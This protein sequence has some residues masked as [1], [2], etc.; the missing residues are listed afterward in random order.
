MSLSPLHLFRVNSLLSVIE[1]MSLNNETTTYIECEVV[2]DAVKEAVMAKIKLKCLFLV[3][4]FMTVYFSIVLMIRTR[5]KKH[6]TKNKKMKKHSTKNKKQPK[7]ID[8]TFD[9]V[10]Y[11]E[12]LV[13]STILEIDKTKDHEAGG[14][15]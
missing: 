1:R 7:N 2:R 8:P 5:M 14:G 3:L 13:Q 11:E 12:Y 4:C 15:T 9:T 10:D 6:S